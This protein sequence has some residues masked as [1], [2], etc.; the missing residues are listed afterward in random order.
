[1]NKYE[2]MVQRLS[3]D[4]ELELEGLETRNISEE[5]RKGNKALL[6]DLERLIKLAFLIRSGQAKIE[7]KGSDEE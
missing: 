6:E 7:I 3:A 4:F 5:I 1:M 2:I